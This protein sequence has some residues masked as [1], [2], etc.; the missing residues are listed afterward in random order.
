[1]AFSSNIRVLSTR[2]VSRPKSES[3]SSK[4]VDLSSKLSFSQVNITA[5]QPVAPFA[6]NHHLRPQTPS[7][8]LRSRTPTQKFAISQFSLDYADNVVDDSGYQTQGSSDCYAG[9]ISAL[10]QNYEEPIEIS[11]QPNSNNAD[12]VNE[13]CR[14]QSSRKRKEPG[15]PA[16]PDAQGRDSF[17]S[18]RARI[19]A[20]DDDSDTKGATDINTPYLLLMTKWSARMALGF[21]NSVPGPRIEQENLLEEIDIMSEQG[22]DMS[23][24]C[25]ISTKSIHRAILNQLSLQSLP[26]AFQFRLAGCKNLAPNNTIENLF[27]NH[28]QPRRKRGSAQSIVAGLT[29]WIGPDAM[30]HL[31]AN[32]ERAGGVITAVVLVRRSGRRAPVVQQSSPETSNWRTTTKTTTRP[33]TPSA[34]SAWWADQISGSRRAS[35]TRS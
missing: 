15:S 6:F 9:D 29:T 14:Y 1:M 27:R 8:A 33:P 2:D 11:K 26:A 28:N 34:L 20:T 3:N 7:P 30:Y 4:F 32:V 25:G 23:D 19:V 22:S 17:P 24:G 5:F 16:S 13:G 31:W 18:K 10:V 35:S 21:S 12:D